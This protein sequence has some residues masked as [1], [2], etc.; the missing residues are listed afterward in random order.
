MAQESPFRPHIFSAMREILMVVISILIALEVNNWNENRQNRYA[1][2]RII[3]DLL[4]ELRQDSVQMGSV[5]TWQQTKQASLEEVVELLRSSAY[6]NVERIDSLYSLAVSSNLTFFPSKGVYEAISSSGKLELIEDDS[7]KYG[8]AE[9]YERFYTRLIYNGEIYDRWADEINW[10][11]RT[12]I[13]I[14]A[15]GEAVMRYPGAIESTEFLANVE[16]LYRQCEKHNELAEGVYAEI[17]KSLE[18]LSRYERQ[19]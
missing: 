3:D 2:H 14:Q 13:D 18:H 15:G 9:L 7:L 8:V 5:L 17:Q 19:L 1:E 16:Y 6:S 12:L 11:Q 10:Q 4:V